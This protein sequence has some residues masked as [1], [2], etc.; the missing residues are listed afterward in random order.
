M[1]VYFVQDKTSMLVLMP[2]H[3]KDYLKE[4]YITRDSNFMLRIDANDCACVI[5]YQSNNAV[6]TNCIVV[7]IQHIRLSV[8]STSGH[9]ESKQH[10][11]TLNL[12]LP[13]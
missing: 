4:R 13:M 10:T 2:V 12:Q 9:N 8:N 3:D 5:I 1:Y 11:L 7:A 6:Q